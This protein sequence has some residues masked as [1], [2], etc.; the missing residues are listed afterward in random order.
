MEIRP[1]RNIRVM[2]FGSFDGM[3][4]GH[5]FYLSSAKKLG[6]ELIVI[7]ARDKTI[8]TVKHHEPA[9]PETKRLALVQQHHAVDSA[10]LGEKYDYFS[11]LTRFSPDILALGYDQQTFS[12]DLSEELAKRRLRAKIVRLPAFM[13]AKYKSSKLRNNL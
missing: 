13:P 6:D 1:G 4:P 10:Y 2:A 8:R 3:H 5:D 9:L 7:V 12:R 11:V